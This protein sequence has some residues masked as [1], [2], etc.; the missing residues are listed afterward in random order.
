MSSFLDLPAKLRV[1]VYKNLIAHRVEPDQDSL[2]IVPV[3]AGLRQSCR[4]VREEFDYEILPLL[5]QYQ[6]DIVQ[7]SFEADPRVHHTILT[8][9]NDSRVLELSLPLEYVVDHYE[10]NDVYFGGNENRWTSV[11]LLRALN[12]NIR[13]V[14]IA[15][16]F[17]DAEK[18]EEFLMGAEPVGLMCITMREALESITQLPGHRKPPKPLNPYARD[19]EVT[20]E[21][22][23]WSEQERQEFGEEVERT[24][25]YHALHL[26]KPTHD[27]SR[28]DKTILGLRW[29]VK[30]LAEGRGV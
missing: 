6:H 17:N 26:K 30:E 22:E 29:D 28:Q 14:S 24:Y 21:N 27:V 13:T 8:T 18:W 5:H 16:C 2:P 4:L 15:I 9:F 20:W 7:Q 12:P 25:K 23:V 1:M 10:F 11:A 19:V 3:Y